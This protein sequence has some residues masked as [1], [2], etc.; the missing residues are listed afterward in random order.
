MDLRPALIVKK[1]QLAIIFDK[2]FL[3]CNDLSLIL[4]RVVFI[5]EFAACL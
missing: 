1:L 3:K 5:K 2:F 4:D